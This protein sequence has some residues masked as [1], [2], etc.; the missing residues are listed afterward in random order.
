MERAESEEGEKRMGTRTRKWAW[1]EH[2]GE[3]QAVVESGMKTMK[4]GVN[5]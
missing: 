1:Q 2:G 5:E 3:M 4:D